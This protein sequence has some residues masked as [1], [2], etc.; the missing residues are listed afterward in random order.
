M[1]SVFHHVDSYRGLIR[2][3]LKQD[4][5]KLHD[6][7]ATWDVLLHTHRFSQSTLNLQ[8]QVRIRHHQKSFKYL[9]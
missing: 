4:K 5:A 6:F 1:N 2:A 7:E 8:R 3:L 9:H